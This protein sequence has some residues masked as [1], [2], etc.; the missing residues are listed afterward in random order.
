[1]GQLW[2]CL[3]NGQELGPFDT[4]HILGLVSQRTLRPNDHVRLSG[5]AA[6]TVASKIK[7][8]FS[9]DSLNAS[10]TALANRK[11]QWKVQLNGRELGPFSDRQ[12]KRFAVRGDLKPHYLLQVVGDPEWREARRIQGLFDA[13]VAQQTDRG[14]PAVSPTDKYKFACTACGRTLSCYASF[15]RKTLPCPA[16][17]KLLTVPDLASASSSPAS[18]STPVPQA[19]PRDNE[20]VVIKS[21]RL[22]GSTAEPPNG[23]SIRK[24]LGSIRLGGSTPEKVDH[25]PP[26]ESIEFYGAGT[27]VDLGFG[28]LSS[29]LVYATAQRFGSAYDASL[30]ELPLPATRSPVPPESLPYWPTYHEATPRQRGRYLDWLYGGRKDP[31]IELGYVFIFFYG[32]ERR[33]LIDGADHAIVVDELLRLLAAYDKSNS[34]QNY[35]TSLLWLTVFLTADRGGL[36]D[37]TVTRVI[38]STSRWDEDSLKFSLGYYG[39]RGLPLPTAMTVAVASYDERSVNSVV[40]SRHSEKFHT[41][42][43]SRLTAAYPNGFSLPAKNRER[44]IDYRA[45]SGTMLA[46]RNPQPEIASRTVPTYNPSTRHFAS[47]ATLWNQC[48]DELRDFDRAS[49]RDGSGT[50]TSEM[51]EALPAELRLGEHPE[52]SAWQRVIEFGLDDAGWPLVKISQLSQIKKFPLRTQLTKKQCETL[53][54]TADALGLSIEPDARLTGKNYRCDEVVVVFQNDGP[55]HDARSLAQ[56][57]SAATLLQLS[58]AI[59]KADEV[60][61]EVELGKIANHIEREFDLSPQLTKRLEGLKHLLVARDQAETSVAQSIRKSLAVKERKVIGSFLVAIAAS[62]RVICEKERK[63][64]KKAFRGLGI[65]SHELEKMLEQ[66]DAIELAANSVGEVDADSASRTDAPALCLE[67]IR[68]IREETSR[69]QELLHTVLSSAESEWTAGDDPASIISDA[70]PDDSRRAAATAV[71]VQADGAVA[72]VN[73][74]SLLDRMPERYRAFFAAIATQTSWPRSALAD[75][76]RANSL[77]LNAA[78]E[79]INEWSTEEI[80]DWLIEEDDDHILIHRHLLEI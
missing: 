53:L 36:P 10:P 57:R 50:V 8:L 6:W 35:A 2:H 69:V 73:E 71:A 40:V 11:R 13:P 78:C 47:L 29:P 66:H 17:K 26:K 49:R 22:T 59:A 33:V 80:G 7:G 77:M 16:C 74:G 75:I 67:R 79:A 5:T 41:L 58:L 31:S 72:V 76:A 21:R 38:Q 23:L 9:E 46:A 48:V 34:F 12:L 3:I 24:I 18:V 56:Y 15:F 14:L 1:M 28:P 63:A 54:A 61:D 62:D 45:A 19:P 4:S 65:P 20:P 55:S 64:L 70:E 68:A 39:R 44:K 37:E 60:L 32:L 42:F 52:R 27:V 43:K 25:R 51:Y 30:I